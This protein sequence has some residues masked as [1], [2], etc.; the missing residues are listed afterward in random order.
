MIERGEVEA[1]SYEVQ[2]SNNSLILRAR[3]LTLNTNPALRY[4]LQAGDAVCFDARVV[5]GSPGNP[6]SNNNDH[7]RVAFRF[8]GDDC[9]YIDRVGESAIP[10]PEIEAVHGLRHGDRLAS[11]AFPVVFEQAR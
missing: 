6:E 10:T 7:R 3:T 11:E 1:L 9:V 8:G 4:Q 2:A 5:H